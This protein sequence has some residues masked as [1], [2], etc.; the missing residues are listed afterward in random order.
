MKSVGALVGVGVAGLFVG[1][2]VME[3]IH[4]V[5]PNLVKEVQ[6]STKKAIADI[7]AAFKEGYYGLAVDK[8]T[9]A[10]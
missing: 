10:D 5:R 6:A 7:G 3:V 9:A 1:A 2:L 8:K 4:R